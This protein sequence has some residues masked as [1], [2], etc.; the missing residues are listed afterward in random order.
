MTCRRWIDGR[1]WVDA[2]P[3][4]NCRH[5]QRDRVTAQ[6]ADWDVLYDCN[7]CKRCGEWMS[8]G[9]AND[10]SEA[11]QIEIRAAEIAFE[12]HGDPGYLARCIA[13]HGDKP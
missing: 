9:P 13:E 2:P 6:H 11:V 3:L 7:I 12:W 5:P 4:N 1:G 10:D 8:L